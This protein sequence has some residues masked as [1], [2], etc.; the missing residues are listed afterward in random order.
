MS[1]AAH[2]RPR[3][4]KTTALGRLCASCRKHAPQ[5][6][7]EGGSLDLPRL[8]DA[9]VTGMLAIRMLLLLEISV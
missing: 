4:G 8:F 9:L 3:F 7:T 1:S 5:C 2:L 6:A